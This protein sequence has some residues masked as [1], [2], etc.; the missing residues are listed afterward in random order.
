MNTAVARGARVCG[1]A[2]YRLLGGGLWAMGSG[3]CGNQPPVLSWA[4]FGLRGFVQMIF[5]DKFDE[6]N[7]AARCFEISDGPPNSKR[8][9][10][11]VPWLLGGR[12]FLVFAV[13]PFLAMCGRV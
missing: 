9:V 10:A 12:R 5:D 8:P 13:E 7:R 11:W 2:K 6:F 3:G 1:Q 4:M